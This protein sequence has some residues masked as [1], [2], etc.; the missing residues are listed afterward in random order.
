[1]EP[2]RPARGLRR[3]AVTAAFAGV[4]ACS[5]IGQDLDVERIFDERNLEPIRR[6]LAA[7]E[8]DLTTRICDAAIQRGQPSPEWRVIRMMGQRALGDVDGAL[9]TAEAALAK[10]PDHLPLLMLRHDIAARFGRAEAAA[11]SLRRVNESARKKPA[12][13]RTAAEMIAL[14]QAAI[15][16]GADARKVIEQ[17]FEPAKRKDPKSEAAYLAAGA[18]ALVKEDFTRA[19]DEFRKG[20]KEHGETADLRAGLARAFLPSDREKADEN[21]GRALEINPRHEDAQ[22]L[23]A[24][25]LIGAEKFLDAEALIQNV[26][27]V[28]EH[29]AEAWGL[30]LAVSE[31]LVDA[32]RAQA[33]RESG[34]KIW[35]RNPVVDMVAGRVLSRAYRFAEAAAHQRQALDFAPDYLPAK[36]QLCHALL[37]LGE[38]DEAWKLA[39]EIRDKDGYNVQAHNIG[40]LE[41]EIARHAIHRDADF[42]LKMPARERDIY[43]ERALA[44]LREA[45]TVLAAK[46]GLELRRPVL[47]EFFPA[48]Q[49]FAIRTFG[50]LG[51]QGMLGACFGSVVTMNSPGS[52]AHGR[53]NWESTLWHEFCHVITLSVTKNRMPRWLS[54]GISVHEERLRDPAWGMT[55]TSQFR[56]M[57]VEDGDLTPLTELSSA[58]M[59]PETE[60]HLMLAYYLSSVAVDFLIRRYG[61][62]KF[63]AILKDIAEGKRINAAIAAR[64]EEITKVDEAFKAHVTGIV[65]A[66]EAGLDWKKPEPED[67]DPTSPGALEEFVKKNPRN[68]WALNRRLAEL[69]KNEKWEEAVAAADNLIKLVPEDFGTTS[70]HEAKVTA[71]R[72]LGR[73]KEEAEELRVIAAKNSDATSAYLRLIELAAAERRWDEVIANAARVFAMNPFLKT[74]QL[75]LA[76]ALEAAER[77]DEAAVVCRRLLLMEPDDPGALHFRLARLMRGKDDAGAKRHLLDALVLAPRF[78]EAHKMLL[79]MNGGEVK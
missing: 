74:P 70:A 77:T 6:M 12:K 1:M 29:S 53:S 44:L 72:E 38:E 4:A 39:A 13:D 61:M 56:K 73:A 34:L 51:G 15:A 22:L 58:F 19:A 10:F 45:K 32:K 11:D 8:Y 49:D 31:I 30:R 65:A 50:H 46:Y 20:L 21:A 36:I 62:D 67:L 28:N 33:S 55:M 3:L 79:E 26:L 76:R 64:T 69:M 78:R 60:D 5:L 43:G 37:R 54:E 52:L 18:L 35:P 57:I 27:N 66:F 71:L 24:E 41:K 14:G 23:R 2:R 68:H 25:M 16:L 48:Q 40:L 63:Q 42:I 17:Y 9:Q 47:V 59:A 75:Q 7:G